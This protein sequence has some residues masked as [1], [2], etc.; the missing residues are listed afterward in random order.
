MSATT[1]KGENILRIFDQ[2][3]RVTPWWNYVW[4]KCTSEGKEVIWKTDACSKKETQ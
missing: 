3:Q 1:Q 2:K 4:E